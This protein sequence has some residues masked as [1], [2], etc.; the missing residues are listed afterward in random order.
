M[1]CF[2]LATKSGNTPFT[3]HIQG[4]SL[5]GMF[6]KI[7]P[8]STKKEITDFCDTQIQPSQIHYF[9]KDSYWFSVY[10]VKENYCI[11]AADCKLDASQMSYLYLY[12]FDEKIPMVTA[13]SNI[14]KYTQNEK[15]N[16]IK[17]T[18]EETKKLMHNN[19]ELMLQ[20]QE[21]IEDLAERSDA[22]AKEAVSF[23]HKA[24]E[25]NSCCTLL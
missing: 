19:I 9:N 14:E 5:F 12:L 1:K 16:E 18:L 20:R 7:F 4:N 25:L 3:W 21:K 15:I 24:Q 8:E 23:K 13:A 17:E 11:V 2:G 10:K 22:L 6:S